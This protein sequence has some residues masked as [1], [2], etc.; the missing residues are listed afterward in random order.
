M[1]EWEVALSTLDRLTLAHGQRAGG[2]A[3]AML[4]DISFKLAARFL[5]F[6]HAPGVAHEDEAP[7]PGVRSGGA[8]M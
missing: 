1:G 4:K 8:A 3:T 6:V 7:A 5:V 2:S